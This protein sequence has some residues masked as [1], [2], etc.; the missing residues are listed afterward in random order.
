[1]ISTWYNSLFSPKIFFLN[2]NGEAYIQGSLHFISCILFFIAIIS[3]SM[4]TGFAWNDLFFFLVCSISRLQKVFLFMLVSVSCCYKIYRIWLIDSHY[5]QLS[6][7]QSNFATIDESTGVVTS[8]RADRHFEEE[9]P[10]LCAALDGLKLPSFPQYEVR[11]RCSS[12][13]FLHLSANIIT[14]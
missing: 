4:L 1:M 5:C 13:R 6:F 10:V 7:S 2:S 11:V 12:F 9:G 8:R 14:L 3:C